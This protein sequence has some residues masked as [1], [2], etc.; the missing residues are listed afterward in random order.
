MRAI[1][2]IMLTAGSRPGGTK[3]FSSSNEKTFYKD[4]VASLTAR[5][6]SNVKHSLSSLGVLSILLT[7]EEAEELSLDPRVLTVTKATRMKPTVLQK[8]S[9]YHL[10][11]ISAKAIGNFE[12]ENTGKGVTAYVVDSGV[13]IQHEEFEGRATLGFKYSFDAVAGQHGSHVAGLVGSKTYGVAKKA[14]IVDINVGDEELGF[15]TSDILAGLNWIATNHIEGTPG[16][17]N[18]SFG[19]QVTLGSPETAV[20]AALKALV[21]DGLNVV[22]AAGNDTMDTYL[23]SPARIDEAIT[24]GATAIDNALSGFSNFGPAVDILAPGSGIVSTGPMYNDILD[25]QGTSMAAPIVAGVVAAYIEDNLNT[26]DKVKLEIKRQARKDLCTHDY[27]DTTHDV[28]YSKMKRTWEGT[29]PSPIRLTRAYSI[30][31]FNTI[32]DTRI[33]QPTIKLEKQAVFSAVLQSGKITTTEFVVNQTVADSMPG[34][35]FRTDG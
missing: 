17:I 35:V 26:P 31:P 27:A 3:Q 14:S 21:A 19:H 25:L 15:A 23:F 6:G 10:S 33:Y 11:I 24:V 1:Y 20:E 9:P 2:D 34:E 8:N 28:V 18:C 22:I 29:G 4:T 30:T 12:Y 32:G 7:E 13:N 16:V 5:F